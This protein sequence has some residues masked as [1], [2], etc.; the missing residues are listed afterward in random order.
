MAQS[1]G[2]GIGHII[3]FGRRGQAQQ[4]DHHKLNLLFLCPSMPDHRQLYLWR[5]VFS[6][7]QPLGAAGD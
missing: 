5:T 2:Q 4:L 7:I 6:D 3:W 1:D